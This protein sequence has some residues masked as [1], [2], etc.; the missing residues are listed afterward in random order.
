MKKDIYKYA[1]VFGIVVIAIFIIYL[2]FQKSDNT[3]IQTVEYRD[4][5]VE[6]RNPEPITITK[7][8]TKIEYIR[9]TIITTKPFT[10]RIDTIIRCD[11]VRAQFDF[12]D[13]TFSMTLNRKNDTIF[14]ERIFNN[15]ILKNEEKWWHK[16][17]LCILSLCGGYLFGRLIK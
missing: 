3:K 5:I 17:A 15:N 14:R 4:T 7:Y 2:L 12:P 11:T 13:N 6:I 9:D 1:V 8:K 10:A 16:P